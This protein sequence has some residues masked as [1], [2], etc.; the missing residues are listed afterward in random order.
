[1]DPRNPNSEL[2]KPS[3]DPKPRG[4][5]RPGAG[6]KKGSTTGRRM[7]RGVVFRLRDDDATRLSATAK[8]LG[9]T[10]ARLVRSFVHERIGGPRTVLDAAE[11]ELLVVALHELRKQGANLNQLAFCLNCFASGNMAP[12][13]LKLVD[14]DSVIVAVTEA[15]KIIGRL[16]DLLALKRLD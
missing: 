2:P 16:G 6:R 9:W 13:G 14:A 12:P 5:A 10:K 3:P 4:G 7:S 15:R 8:E 11:R 1:M